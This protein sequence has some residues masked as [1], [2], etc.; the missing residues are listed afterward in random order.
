MSN[1]QIGVLRK[2]KGESGINGG[3]LFKGC[4][5]LVGKGG[6]GWEG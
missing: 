5:F 2:G 4:E 6:I 1:D 3:I